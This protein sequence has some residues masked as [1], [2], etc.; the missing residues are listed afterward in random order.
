M[1]Q[2]GQ[3]SLQSNDMNE[4]LQTQ[5][6]VLDREERKK[7]QQNEQMQNEQ[8][9]Q[10]KPQKKEKVQ[11]NTQEF[12]RQFT[13]QQQQ[14]AFQESMSQVHQHYKNINENLNYQQGGGAFSIGSQVQFIGDREKQ[15]SVQLIST[16]QI[17]EDPNRY[18]LSTRSAVDVNYQSAHN[19]SQI[20]T[21]SIIQSLRN[22]PSTTEK[23][24][25][26]SQQLDV[27]NKNQSKNLQDQSM[28]HSS[29]NL[30]QIFTQNN[31]NNNNNTNNVTNNISFNSNSL[32]ETAKP[33][34]SLNNSNIPANS[35]NYNLPLN[36]PIQFQSNQ[37]AGLN[38][39][40]LQQTPIYPQINYLGQQ[41]IPQISPSIIS[42]QYP[43]MSANMQFIYPHLIQPQGSFLVSQPN[44]NF[45]QIPNQNLVIQQ[46]QQQPQ[47][48]HHSQ[49]QQQ[50]IVPNQNQNPIQADSTIN[51]AFNQQ[52]ANNLQAHT[53]QQ[54]MQQ[55]NQQQ[56]LQNQQFNNLDSSFSNQNAVRAQSN[57]YQEQQS[58][59]KAFKNFASALPPCQQMVGFPHKTHFSHQQN[60]AATSNNS[61]GFPQQNSGFQTGIP[62]KC[63]LNTIDKKNL[64][65]SFS[66]S[67]NIPTFQQNTAFSEKL[68]CIS[69]QMNENENMPSNLNQTV[70]SVLQSNEV[71]NLQ[72]NF[73]QADSQ[74]INQKIK[75]EEDNYQSSSTHNK[76]INQ[77]SNQLQKFSDK[78]A[79]FF[80]SSLQESNSLT[81]QSMKQLQNRDKY[82]SP[83]QVEYTILEKNYD[84]KVTSQES[85]RIN[86]KKNIIQSEQISNQNIQFYHTNTKKKRRA[87][88]FVE[89]IV[90]DANIAEKKLE[91]ASDEKSQGL[92]QSSALSARQTEEQIKIQ[93]QTKLGVKLPTNQNVM[94]LD[95]KIEEKQNMQTQKTIEGQQ[96]TSQKANPNDQYQMKKEETQGQTSYKKIKTQQSDLKGNSAIVQTL[97]S[98]QAEEVNQIE[99]LNEKPRKSHKQ[100]DYQQIPQQSYI[101]QSNYSN[102]P[103]IGEMRSYQQQQIHKDVQSQNQDLSKIISGVFDQNE[104]SAIPQFQNNFFFQFPI[105]NQI[106]AEENENLTHDLEIEYQ[107]NQSK[108]N[109]NQF[110]KVQTNSS[111]RI[112]IAADFNF[113]NNTTKNKH[114]QDYQNSKIN[115]SQ[116]M[117]DSQIQI[118]Q[119]NQQINNPGQSL[120][121]IQP[122]QIIAC[123][124]SEQLNNQQ[125]LQELQGNMQIQ[126]LQNKNQEDATATANKNK[127]QSFFNMLNGQMSLFS[128]LLDSVQCNLNINSKQYESLTQTLDL[129]SQLLIDTVQ[130]VRNIRQDVDDMILHSQDIQGQ[131]G[132][133]DFMRSRLKEYVR[134]RPDILLD[135]DGF[136]LDSQTSFYSKYELVLKEGNFN[137]PLI[138]DKNFVI[139]VSLI[140]SISKREICNLEP[141]PVRLRMYNYNNPPIIFESDYIKGIL[142]QDLLKGSCTFKKIHIKQVT[143]HQ[144]QKSMFIVVEPDIERMYGLP[145]LK[146][147][148]QPQTRSDPTDLRGINQLKQLN[149]SDGG[150]KLEV[151]TLEEQVKVK[152]ESIEKESFIKEDYE[153]PAFKGQKSC[154]LSKELS[155]TSQKN[156]SK[157]QPAKKKESRSKKS[158][159]DKNNAINKQEQDII[160]YKINPILIKP[161][162]LEQI[163]VKSKNNMSSKA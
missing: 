124:K 69:E 150:Y 143:S 13:N 96:Q 16:G 19:I 20:S 121:F 148:K 133:I 43:Q 52:I 33:T 99:I 57:Q 73:N 144:K 132:L 54:Y 91:L 21:L 81:R 156:D 90:S 94:F 101:Q 53:Q 63:S 149:E 72:K 88:E 163:I 17:Q 142:G 67:Q 45:V 115:L 47:Q 14:Q 27:Q 110:F 64:Q 126:H 36:P 41:Q 50:G 4:Q 154:Q 80:Q 9:Y 140:D 160:Q 104:Q 92:S 102:I 25:S 120:Q 61:L 134:S 107:G 130:S 56:Q 12:S 78:Q 10:L 75:Q 83:Q 109:Q 100:K 71:Y 44:Y 161:L 39:V 87:K 38:P 76:F 106:I 123:D 122:N 103:K 8:L 32:I 74:Q 31:I 35:M 22:I 58:I 23:M 118:S 85:K 59:E 62:Q 82:D 129:Q 146:L 157:K 51:Q 29:N 158:N 77:D 3:Q 84:K 18:S 128:F 141:I 24:D 98:H 145:L 139:G 155:M 68:Q 117:L 40:A 113:Q 95:K 137:E 86:D 7:I 119:N 97:A 125:N 153:M 15:G 162:I 55:I 93:Q 159:S 5:H 28:G 112:E 1:N 147:N 152:Q 6:H 127:Q 34:I 114:Q 135:Y 105:E 30:N 46:Q 66:S 136:K 42:T 60:S 65:E 49:Q 108:Q 48:Q 151:L 2:K 89:E 131:S 26:T 138:K 111:P 70:K 37:Q 79:P 116:N 11:N